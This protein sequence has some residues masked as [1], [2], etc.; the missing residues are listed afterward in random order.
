MIVSLCWVCCIKEIFY[1]YL[2]DFHE[3]YELRTN[4]GATKWSI[5]NIIST[6][7]AQKVALAAQVFLVQ[8]HD[9]FLAEEH[10]LLWWVMLLLCCLFHKNLGFRWLQLGFFCFN[11]IVCIILELSNQPSRSLLNL[12]AFCDGCVVVLDT[13]ATPE[14]TMRRLTF[15]WS[16]NGVPRLAYWTR[17][18][19]LSKPRVANIALQM[20]TSL[21]DTYPT[22]LDK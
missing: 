1:F 22:G 15:N 7:S 13:I 16:G 10:C 9:S 19:Q 11:A 3:V 17:G 6:A 5:A 12:T 14:S 8:R 4:R 20:E 18:G 21:L 2:I